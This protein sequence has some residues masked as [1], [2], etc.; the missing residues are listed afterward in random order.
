MVLSQI[1][2]YQL[3][4]YQYQLKK[5]ALMNQMGSIVSEFLVIVTVSEHCCRLRL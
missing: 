5:M 1:Y 3:I 2:Q 4:N